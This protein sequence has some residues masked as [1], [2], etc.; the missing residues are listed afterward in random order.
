MGNPVKG[1][2]S[3]EADAKTFTLVFDF[4]AICELEDAFDADINSIGELIGTKASSVRKVFRVGLSRRHPDLTEMEAGDIISV[5]GPAEAGV[6]I[7]KAFALSF[8]PA[9][10]AN[11]TTRPPKKAS[12]A[13]TG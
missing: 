1:E 2:V 8:P 4:N 13:G 5:I 11:G 12:R 9:E 3:F 6:L 7:Q 10:A